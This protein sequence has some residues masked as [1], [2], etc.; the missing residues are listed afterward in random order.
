MMNSY[1]EQSGFYGTPSSADQSYRFPIGLGM[2]PYAQHHHQSRAPQDSPYDATAAACKLYSSQSLQD[3]GQGYKVD[4][5]NNGGSVKDVSQNGYN[6]KDLSVGSGGSSGGSSVP[7]WPSGG[8]GGGSGGGSGG[9][10]TPGVPVRPAACTP[11]GRY[12]GG[13]GHPGGVEPASPTR[14]LSSWNATCNLNNGVVSS[15]T[16]SQLQQPAANHTFYPWMA[17]AGLC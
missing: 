11:D 9:S 6:S 10:G 15:Q 7:G 2:S 16:A 1:F 13:P 17:I 4:C 5:T 12:A 14:S 3:S 8:G